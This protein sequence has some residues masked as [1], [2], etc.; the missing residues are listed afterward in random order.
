MKVLLVDGSL[1]LQSRLN[2]A[3]HKLDNDI[4]IV[5]TNCCKEAT[6]LFLS[7]QPDLLILDI[8]LPDGSGIDLLQTFKKIN[9]EI[10]VA[11]LTNYPTIEFSNRCKVL[12]ADY[13]FDKKNINQ[14]L[15]TLK[16]LIL[17][18]PTEIL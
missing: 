1:L 4:Q 11:I 8:A 7:F 9:P 6:S 18:H 2:K 15:N 12:G 5:Q 13:F 10:I 14:L 16:P 17:K 3:L